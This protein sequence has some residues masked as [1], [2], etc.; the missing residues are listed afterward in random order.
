MI[1]TDK[2]EGTNWDLKGQFS[3]TEMADE[4]LLLFAEVKR[5]RENESELLSAISQYK[6]IERMS[7]G[8]I[9]KMKELIE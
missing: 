9:Q 8:L 5:L 2:Y 6:D 4:V 1:D 3:H 7:L